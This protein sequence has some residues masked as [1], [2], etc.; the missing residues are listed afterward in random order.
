M[1][2]LGTADSLCAGRSDNKLAISLQSV[3]AGSGIDERL[4]NSILGKSKEPVMKLID[5]VRIILDN[6]AFTDIQEI[7]NACYYSGYYYMS[8]SMSDEAMYFLKKAVDIFETSNRKSEDTYMKCLNSIAICYQRMGDFSKSIE[9][10][11]RALNNEVIKSGKNPSIEV[12]IYQSMAYNYIQSGDFE[13]SID[14]V[15]RGL[16]TIQKINGKLD[17]S[18]IRLLYITKGSA[19]SSMSNYNQAIINLEKAES[20]YDQE[21]RKDDLYGNMLDNLAT[22]YHFIGLKEKSYKYFEKGIRFFNNDLSPMSFNLT[23]N[24]ALVLAND[25]NVDKGEKLI[26]DFLSRVQQSPVKRSRNYYLML[27]D[28]GDFLSDYRTETFRAEKVYKECYD[29]VY[30]H[31]WDINLRNKVTLGYA[32]LL[33]KTGKTEIA[34][35][36]LQALLFDQAEMPGRH[37]ILSDPEPKPTREALDLLRSKF[38]MLKSEYARAGNFKFLQASANTSEAIIEVLE[39]IRLNIGEEGSRLILGD[40]YRGIYIEAINC[41]KECYEKTRDERYLEKIFSYSEKSKVASLLASTRE[42]KA[43]Q[44]YIP[45]NLAEMERETQQKIGNLDSKIAA[46]EQQDKPDRLKMQRWKDELIS[47]TEKRDSLINYFE[48]HFPSYYSLK[49]DTRVADMKDITKL[50]GRSGNYISYILSDSLIYILVTNRKHSEL[51]TEKIDTSF[52]NLVNSFR[53]ILTDPDLDLDPMKEFIDYQTYG[54]KLY[55][56]LIKPIKGFL[57]SGNLIISPDNIISYIPFETLLTNNDVHRDLIYRNLPYVINDFQISYTYSATLLAESE[58][59]GKA[60][61]NSLIAFA[62][63]YKTQMNLDTI[64]NGRQS[65]GGVLLPL[66]HAL[67]EA[68]F[69][70]K[71]THGNLFSDSASKVSEY[72]R[73]AGA[74]DIIHLA[75]HTVINNKNPGLSKMIFSEKM[76]SS[77]NTGLNLFDIYGVP[78]KSKMVV[79]SSCNTGIGDLFRGEG[80][81]SLARGFIY[82]GSK[83]VVMSLWEVNDASGTEIVKSFY[84]NL[85]KGESKS[86]SLRKARMMYLK[87]VSQMGSHPYFWSTLVIYGDDSPLYYRRSFITVAGITIILILASLFFYFR[88]R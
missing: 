31:P 19:Y 80:V 35:D 4:L 29:F 45:T 68:E 36:S 34:L 46:E 84:T 1:F 77:G 8:L 20:Y 74:F 87:T 14:F 59:P 72:I 66:P 51:I 11:E 12:S 38:S 78:L 23:K 53:N 27:S 28:Y 54:Y 22:A 85:K 88:K 58:S 49:F 26:V 37:D 39:K 44:T 50:V 61:K 41:F 76:D 18:T 69:V 33:N 67:K 13:I 82:S 86:E 55:S 42:I 16:S 6:K 7:T 2:I 73:N 63:V 75:M 24:Y 21:G 81:L 3:K 79:L 30:K 5:T 47:V 40:K 48:K 17:I 10:S 57:V 65:I 43:I 9:Y 64:I 52:F 83:S 56:S 32:K 70:A 71:I 60:L 25:H 15:N 62:P